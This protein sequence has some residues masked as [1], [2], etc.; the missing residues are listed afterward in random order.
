M[1]SLVAAETDFPAG[2]GQGGPAQ[3]RAR[4]RNRGPCQDEYQQPRWG[5][6]VTNHPWL[7]LLAGVLLLGVVALPAAQLRL[8]L[9]D[10]SSEPVASQ[11]FKAYDVTKR[12]FG[13]GMTGP[14]IVVGDLPED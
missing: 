1:L 8:A 3:R 12:S 5:G 13:E 4:P 9:P 11:A 14:I 6:I 7:A 2:L 10:A